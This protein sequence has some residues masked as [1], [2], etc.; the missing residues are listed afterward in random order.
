M[1]TDENELESE[2]RAI[3]RDPLLDHQLE[4]ILKQEI[5]IEHPYAR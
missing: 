2:V 4:S 1:V 5:G 3:E